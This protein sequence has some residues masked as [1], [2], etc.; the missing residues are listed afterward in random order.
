VDASV[1]LRPLRP[2]QACGLRGTAYG[3]L[4]RPDQVHGQ[5][6]PWDSTLTL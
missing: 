2:S 4:R 1:S 3:G 5:S 6:E